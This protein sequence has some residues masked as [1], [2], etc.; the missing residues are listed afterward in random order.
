MKILP[1]YEISN[2]FWD[3]VHNAQSMLWFFNP[4]HHNVILQYILLWLTVITYYFFTIML[5]FLNLFW[6][7]PLKLSPTKQPPLLEL[8]ID[9]DNP[10]R[11]PS[12]DKT[13]NLKHCRKKCWWNAAHQFGETVSCSFNNSETFFPNIHCQL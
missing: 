2:D 11:K 4:K 7:Y 10:N 1:D 3:F 5:C 8:F 6:N 12:S 13:H 9:S